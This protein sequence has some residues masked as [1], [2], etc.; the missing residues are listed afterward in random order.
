MV[1]LDLYTCVLVDL[2][3]ICACCKLVS[4]FNVYH[5][6]VSS[7]LPC[8]SE[9]EIVNINKASQ[10]NKGLTSLKRKEKKYI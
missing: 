6:A 5:G 1:D 2:S 7:A 10:G 3:C 9:G 8:S 4:T